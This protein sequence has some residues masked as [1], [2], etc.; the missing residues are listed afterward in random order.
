MQEKFNFVND[1]ENHLG[2]LNLILQGIDREAADIYRDWKYNLHRA[3]KNNMWIDG[4]ARARQQKPK[5]FHTLDQWQLA[6]D[7]FESDEYKVSKISI[8]NNFFS[9]HIHFVCML[10]VKS[11]APMPT[12]K[13]ERRW[14]SLV[15]RGHILLHKLGTRR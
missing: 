8:H 11:D 3:Y 6:C 4:I 15:H 2:D 5:A 1:E 9:F 13:I 14:S 7:L 10:H 12:P